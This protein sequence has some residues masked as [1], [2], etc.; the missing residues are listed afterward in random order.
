MKKEGKAI[1]VSNKLQVVIFSATHTGCGSVV[2]TIASQQ[3]CRREF[4]F[5]LYELVRPPKWDYWQQAVV[6]ND[7]MAVVCCSLT[8]LVTHKPDLGLS[9]PLHGRQSWM[10]PIAKSTEAAD[11]DG[12]CISVQLL[13]QFWLLKLQLSVSYS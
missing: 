10:L 8:F 12:K 2:S 5:C 11:R 4:P 13:K 7:E 9:Y 6:V 1:N 3:R